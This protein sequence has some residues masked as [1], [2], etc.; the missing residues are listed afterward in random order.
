[1]T[2]PSEMSSRHD[3]VFNVFLDA[4]AAILGGGNVTSEVG[5]SDDELRKNGGAW[6]VMKC[7]DALSCSVRAVHGASL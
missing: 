7:A 5:T 2:R 6:S 1:M 3:R 4:K